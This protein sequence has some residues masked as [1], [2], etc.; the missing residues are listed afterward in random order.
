[1]R[2]KGEEEEKMGRGEAELKGRRG[3][4][5]ESG[6]GGER[7]RRR[8]EED[9]EMSGRVEGKTNIKEDKGPVS[10]GEDDGRENK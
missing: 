5:E 1:M 6:G 7:R 10:R 4:G 8:R 9:E 3:E 2:R